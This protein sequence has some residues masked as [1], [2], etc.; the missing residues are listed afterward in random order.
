MGNYNQITSVSNRLQEAMNMRNMKAVEL[1]EKSGI[2]RPAISCYLSGK[3]EPKQTPLY[4]MG[5]ALDVSELWLAGYD[6]PM[7]RP[8]EQKETDKKAQFVDNIT[9]RLDKEKD[10]K[11]LIEKISSLKPEEIKILNSLNEKQIDFIRS[12]LLTLGHQD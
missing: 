3:Y 2:S 5:V 11:E 6:V 10:F 7:D 9:D 8:P 1:S 12:Y 4:R